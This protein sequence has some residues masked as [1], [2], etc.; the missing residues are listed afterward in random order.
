[1][2]HFDCNLFTLGMDP[3]PKDSFSFKGVAYSRRIISAMFKISSTD[4]VDAAKSGEFVSLSI[5]Y[6]W[7]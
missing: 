1:M 6:G 3:R 5:L 2:F 7:N 4:G